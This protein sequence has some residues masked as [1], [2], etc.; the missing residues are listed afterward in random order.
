VEI[1]SARRTPHRPSAPGSGARAVAPA[2]GVCSAASQKATRLGHRKGRDMGEGATPPPTRI[3]DT[4]KR[5]RIRT[6][7][8]LAEAFW[9]D[10]DRRRAYQ[11][12]VNFALWSALGS[13]AGL[14][15]KID[16]PLGIYWTAFAIV[17]LIFIG[18]FYWFRWSVGI[19]RRNVHDQQ[20][21]HY[22]WGRV[23]GD[24]SKDAPWP[25]RDDPPRAFDLE[26]KRLKQDSLKVIMHWSHGSEIIFT[27]LLVFLGIGAAIRSCSS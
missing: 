7:L 12:K 16:Q 21:A 27:L 5:E 23:D 6:S 17:V 18:F 3:T 15:L 8:R 11:W 9:R 20:G 4:A 13:F 26:W 1:A 25:G 24:P 14:S 19:M 22:Y 10:Y 2:E